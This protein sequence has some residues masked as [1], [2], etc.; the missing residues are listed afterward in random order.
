[1]K[2]LLVNGSPHANGATA[3]A[4]SLVEK[5]LTENGAEAEWFHIGNAPVRGCIDCRQCEK[6]GRCAFDDDKANALADAMAAADG[7]IIGTPVYYAAPNGALCALLDRVFYSRM[8][9]GDS[10]PFR[11]KPAAAVSV[12][13]RSGTTSSM[14]RLNKYFTISEMPIISSVYWNNGLL[15]DE[16]AGTAPFEEKVM[17]TLG[18]NMAKFLKALDGRAIV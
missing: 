7:V 18:A 10:K 17:T 2:V 16:E 1:M 8:E 3:K 13:W 9:F 12:C 6:L 4:L 11:G 14:D 5:G 15:L